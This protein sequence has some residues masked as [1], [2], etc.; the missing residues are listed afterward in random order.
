MLVRYVLISLGT[1]SAYGY[2]GFCVVMGERGCSYAMVNV[3]A[4]LSTPS[5]EHMVVASSQRHV[6]SRAQDSMDGG[7]GNSEDMVSAHFFE[8]SSTLISF[9]LIGSLHSYRH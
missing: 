8:I 2:V 6:M 4:K 1:L 9:V 5:S 7:G 3:I